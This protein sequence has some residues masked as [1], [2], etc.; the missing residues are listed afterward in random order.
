MLQV[1]TNTSIVQYPVTLVIDNVPVSARVTAFDEDQAIAFQYGRQKVEELGKREAATLEDYAK[2][3]KEG[4]AIVK[5]AVAAHLAIEAGQLTVNGVEVVT[6]ADFVA[7]YPVRFDVVAAAYTVIYRE[8]FIGD[9]AKKE[10]RWLSASYV[11]SKVP[12]VKNPTPHGDAPAL[13]AT[14]AA[15]S[16]S[17]N[18]GA[19]VEKPESERSGE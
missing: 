4:R 10:Q 3:E 14:S 19:A 2:K 9:D 15:P 11:G 8:N 13:T 5:A 18:S 12:D 16:D 17:V 7:A 6:G 1:T